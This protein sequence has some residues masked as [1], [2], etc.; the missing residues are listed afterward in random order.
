MST[1][2]GPHPGLGQIRASQVG[3]HQIGI[4]ERRISQ[5]SSPEFRSFQIRIGEV[6]A[7][8][9]ATPEIGVAKIDVL[10]PASYPFVPGIHAFLEQLKVSLVRHGGYGATVVCAAIT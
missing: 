7:D 4:T 5:I 1:I 3:S 2:G 10:G 6:K 8:Q 9:L